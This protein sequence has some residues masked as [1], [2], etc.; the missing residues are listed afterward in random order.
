MVA[1][2]S[3][4][5]ASSAARRSGVSKA[6]PSVSRAHS[7]P[8]SGREAPMT[9][10]IAS[11]PPERARS[12]G[13]CPCGSSANL[14]ALA[15]LEPRHR[16]IDGAIGGAQAG[17][18][19]VEA[20]DRLVRHFP[21]Q[22]ELVL[23]QRGAE[24]RHGC[25]IAGVHH[26]DDVDIAFDRD[27]RC[28]IMRGLARGGDVVE[29]AAL[30][31]ERRLRRVEIFRLRVFLERAAAEGDDAAA[32][33]GDREHH[34]VAEAVERH[35]DVVAGDQQPGLD[36]VLDRDAVRAE[37]LLEREA[38]G[39]RIAEPELELRRRIEPA[40][41]EIAARLGAVSRR[42]RVL[43]EF[44]RKLHHVMQRLAPRVAR[45]VLARDLRQ[46]HAGH[47]RQPLDR[48]RKAHAF[49]FHDEVEDAAVLAGGEIEP[50][51]LLVVH[52]EGRRLLLV[53]RRQALEL[54][55]RAHELHAPADDL[56]HRK[57]G[58]QLIEKLWREAH[59]GRGLTDSGS[60]VELFLILPIKGAFWAC[61]SPLVT[62][63]APCPAAPPFQRH[64]RA[65]PGHPD[66]MGTP[67]LLS[68][69]AGTSP[70]MTRLLG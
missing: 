41:G 54:A 15:G 27:D 66:L 21:E 29:R 59:G 35:R 53:E 58:L 18:V 33:I 28:A 61:L 39:R 25:G 37:M 19:A 23:G 57:A 51:L 40:V 17:A 12:S 47:L 20:E 4:T 24:R 70:A 31:E 50:G 22:A 42:E 46:R 34:A 56:R 7:I 63:G 60:A 44:R 55:A 43:E 30:V 49:A 69:I 52:E 38:L 8:A 14:Q 9:S 64:G 32:Q 68:E 13:S 67:A 65:C 6:C 36:H 10:A 11:R 1:V 2:T 16:Q 3:L 5:R 45:L 62:G 48:F 26:R